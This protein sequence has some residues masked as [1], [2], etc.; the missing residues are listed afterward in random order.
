M[1][2]YLAKVAITALLVVAISEIAKRSSLMGALLASLPLTSILA[3]IWLYLETGSGEKV[4]ALSA[5][6]L[7]L[8]LPS[9]VP[10]SGLGILAQPGNIRPDH[11]RCL[12]T[13]PGAGQPFRP[14]RVMES[15]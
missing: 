14:G 2:Y 15:W 4:A 5:S 7:W 1:G 10:A 8:V 11:R 9:L 3:F 6:I 12:R 13:R